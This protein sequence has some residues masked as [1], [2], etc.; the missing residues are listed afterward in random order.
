MPGYFV[1]KVGNKEELA[2]VSKYSSK[3]R[4]CTVHWLDTDKVGCVLF[5]C[6]FGRIFCDVEQALSRFKQSFCKAF[7]Q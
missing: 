5:V 6:F 4:T 7:S 1:N 3:D 2:V